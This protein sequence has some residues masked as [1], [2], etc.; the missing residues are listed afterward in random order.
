MKNFFYYNKTQRIGIIILIGLILLSIAATVLIPV[1]FDK[2]KSQTS[3]TEFLREAE[4]FR[5]G[6]I[7][8][9]RQQRYERDFQPFVYRN[10]YSFPK[11]AE[12]KYEL[13]AFNP[14]T[15]DSATFVKLGLKPYIARN[16]L[17]YRAKGGVYRTPEAFQ[18]VYGI[19]PEKFEEL[20]P[21][22]QIPEEYQVTKTTQRET[23]VEE[24]PKNERNFVQKRDDII[25]ELN[26]AD[27]AQLKEIRGIGSAYARRIVSY[28]NVLG[29]YYSV[30]Q[31]REVYG[32]RPE[33]FEQ[34]KH[35]LTADG[36]Q[37]RKIDINTASIE[38]LRSHPYIK[39]FQKAKAIYEFRRK[40]VK[41]NNIDELKVL[42]ELSEEDLRKLTPYLEFK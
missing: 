34:I 24:Q 28:R 27:T 29:G 2:S 9:E 3:D 15:A 30:E 17:K 11:R 37:I 36:H 16:I 5:A 20:K 32:M 10:N 39:S 1:I 19:S 12:E 14:N 23:E 4:K 31:V 40:K 26:E 35:S 7:E 13:F 38:R 18:K 42:D 8:K 41:L 33:A 6:L 22:I 25:V 21:Y